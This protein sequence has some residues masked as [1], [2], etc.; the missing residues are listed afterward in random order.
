[1]FDKI[2]VV[3]DVF[4][5][6]CVCIIFCWK[7]WFRGISAG[8]RSWVLTV[9]EVTWFFVFKNKNSDLSWE[10]QQINPINKVEP[11]SNIDS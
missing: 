5:D 2:F 8:R 4:G 1:M 11:K 9:S 7:F 10:K 6:L 3:Y